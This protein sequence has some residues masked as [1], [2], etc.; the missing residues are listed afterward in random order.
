M[1]KGKGPEF[2]EDDVADLLGKADM[3]VSVPAAPPGIHLGPPT[4]R[5]LKRWDNSPKARRDEPGE[6]A[7]YEFQPVYPFIGIGL[8]AIVGICCAI[9]FLGSAE[10]AAP[11]AGQIVFAKLLPKPIANNE[12]AKQC[13]DRALVFAAKKQQEKPDLPADRQRIRRL[14]RCIAHYMDGERES[15]HFYPGAQVHLTVRKATPSFG[16]LIAD[17]PDQKWS[18]I[19][20]TL[21]DERIEAEIRSEAETLSFQWNF[22]DGDNLAA[23]P[24]KR[25]T[26]DWK[27]I[28]DVD[29]LEAYCFEAYDRYQLLRG[30]GEE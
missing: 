13:F 12:E 3:P 6:T 24:M 17:M 19:N 18:S 14:P 1:A 29:A 20:V 26:G 2:S 16:A 9:A 4:L 27:R 10:S 23:R 28:A 5:S 15:T 7:A 8:L 25:G 22:N 30:Q 21:F 11:P